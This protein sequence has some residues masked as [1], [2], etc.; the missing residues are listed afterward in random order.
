MNLTNLLS[1]LLPSIIIAVLAYYF[2]KTQMQN[3][4]SKRKH[5]TIYKNKKL[6]LPIR[7]QAYERITLF[8]ERINP[9]QLLIRV[10]PIGNLKEDYASL[11]VSTIEQEYEHNLSQQIYVSEESWSIVVSA[12][13]TISKIISDTTKQTDITNAQELREGILTAILKTS[14]PTTVALS[15]LKNEVALLF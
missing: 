9:S 4:H 11:L 12:K 5:N 10:K 2:F 3:E 15:N 1:N 8:L 7:L 6:T 13:N 14:P